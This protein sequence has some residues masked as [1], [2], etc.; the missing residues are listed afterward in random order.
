MA[1]AILGDKMAIPAKYRVGDTVKPLMGLEYIVTRVE[2]IE[3]SGQHGEWAYW[4]HD[5]EGNYY[6]EFERKV[7]PVLIK[8]KPQYKDWKYA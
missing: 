7:S 6:G 5:K 3:W 4:G 2:W 1:D 8:K